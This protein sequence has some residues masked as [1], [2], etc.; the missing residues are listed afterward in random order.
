[1]RYYIVW[2]LFLYFLA[3]FLL[4]SLFSLILRRSMVSL[5]A[6]EKELPEE[7]LRF[8]CR[9]PVTELFGGGLFVTCMLRFGTVTAGI[10]V[11]DIKAILL[12]VCLMVLSGI[13]LVDW[14]SLY[15][16]NGFSAAIAFCGLA[17][18]LCAPELSF[19]ARFFGLLSVSLPMLLLNG[20]IPTAFGGGD[21]K[22]MAACGILLG[23]QAN[24]SAAAIA[25]LTGG[26]YG[27]M[28]ILMRKRKRGECFAFGPFLSLGIGAVLFCEKGIF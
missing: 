18:S 26:I 25:I 8:L 17:D 16:P 20:W 5:Y 27:T 11:P 21:I 10:P 9:F 3:G 19:L 13:S 4:F 22:L 6:A 1:M 15:I 24:I 14:H 12:F 23:W 7:V 28:L 2:V